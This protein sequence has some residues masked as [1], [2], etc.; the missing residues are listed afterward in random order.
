MLLR[1]AFAYQ[2]RYNTTRDG[3]ATN[4]NSSFLHQLFRMAEGSFANTIADHY[5]GR[6][7]S[8]FLQA[9]PR[10]FWRISNDLR[11]YY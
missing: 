5:S 4:A 8:G 3:D 6:V 2:Y 7:E 11:W 10:H 1:N 9:L